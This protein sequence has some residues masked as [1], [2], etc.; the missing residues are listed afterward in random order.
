MYE[1][2]QFHTTNGGGLHT[3]SRSSV[4][5]I[6]PVNQC[7][8]PETGNRRYRSVYLESCERWLPAR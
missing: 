8:A 3:G 4:M 2:R 6:G 1:I 5:S 7:F